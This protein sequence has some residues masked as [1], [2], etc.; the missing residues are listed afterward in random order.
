MSCEEEAARAPWV[1]R[2]MDGVRTYSEAKAVCLALAGRLQ[3]LDAKTAKLNAAEFLQQKHLNGTTDKQKRAEIRA[4][5]DRLR[6]QRSELARQSEIVSRE[7][8][9]AI[10]EAEILKEAKTHEKTRTKGS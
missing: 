10:T 8:Q 1:I 2:K 7:M 6:D 5:V 3:Q 4:R 9:E